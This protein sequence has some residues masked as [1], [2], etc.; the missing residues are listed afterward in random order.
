MTLYCVLWDPVPTKSG[1]GG[2]DYYLRLSSRASSSEETVPLLTH[3]GRRL[4]PVDT[5]RAEDES[6]FLLFPNN[7]LKGWN[8]PPFFLSVD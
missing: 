4:L 5:S 3:G 7:F 8:L 6:F 2:R 1:A